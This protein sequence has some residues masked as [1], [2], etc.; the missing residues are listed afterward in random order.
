MADQE[1]TRTVTAALL[2]IG[3][4]ILSGRTR[5]ENI[6]YIAAYLTRIGIVLREIRVV[7]DSKAE[8]AAAVNELRRRFTYVFTTGGIGPTHDDVTT[9]A[10]AMAFG[11]EVIVDPEAVAAMRKLFSREELT[12]ARLRMARIPK[13]AAL[14]DNAISRAPGFMLENVIVMAGVPR[15]MQVMLDAVAPRLAKGRP[16]LT[17]SIRLD[18]PEGD[19]APG[20]AELQASHPEVQ[21]GSYPFFENKRLGTY[22]VLRSSDEAKLEGAENALWIFIHNEGFAAASG[23]DK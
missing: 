17:R 8:I 19:A 20:L 23:D 12:P 4:E 6:A 14:I 11:V 21:I 3:E 10:I 7:A 13:G 2:V 18:V 22:V 16:I 5:D 1:G 15:I 9:D